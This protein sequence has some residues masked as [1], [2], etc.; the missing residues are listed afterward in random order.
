MTAN[1]NGK[2]I[3]SLIAAEQ[4]QK[5][6]KAIQKQLANAPD[7]HWLWSRLSC[8]QY[9]QCDYQGALDAAHRALAIIPDCPLALWDQANA[10]DMLGRTKEAGRVYSRLLRRG[11]QQIKEPDEDAEE[12]WEGEQ[13]TWA[14]VV[15][16]IFR[17][18]DCLA[19][20]GAP[21]EAVVLYQSFLFF[22]RHGV[23]GIYT[24]EDGMAELK[25]LMPD[26]EKIDKEMIDKE[27]ALKEL[28]TV[29]KQ[30]K[31]LEKVLTHG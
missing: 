3:E 25:K 6:Q 17:I 23:Q 19:K 13:W 27:K 7:N 28:E 12:C 14:L 10:L 2:R 22:L 9:E 29:T 5:A 15:D 18:A 11:F 30:T 24:I 16:C 4:W 31:R 21:E 8:V 20:T 26:K 1:G